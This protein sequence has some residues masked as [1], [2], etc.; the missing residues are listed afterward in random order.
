MARK[1]KSGPGPRKSGAWAPGARTRKRG[2]IGPS[3]WDR[4]AA[5]QIRKETVNRMRDS[6]TLVASGLLK[7][8]DKGHPLGWI[9]TN[10]AHFYALTRTLGSL[11]SLEGPRRSVA[12]RA[13]VAT[14]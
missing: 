7:D 12:G 1:R 8:S 11:V 6:H 2:H 3:N 9:S 10:S 13:S 14:R 4:R 5:Q